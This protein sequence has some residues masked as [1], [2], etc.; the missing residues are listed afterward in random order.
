M[1]ILWWRRNIATSG[2]FQHN[3]QFDYDVN[4]ISDGI[5]IFEGQIGILKVCFNL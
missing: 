4:D 3:F 5:D 1:D 2:D